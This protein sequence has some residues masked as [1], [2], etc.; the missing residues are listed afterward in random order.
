MIAKGDIL[1]I[2]VAVSIKLWIDDLAESSHWQTY[3]P[4]V[5]IIPLKNS[6]RKCEDVLKLSK[7]SSR[8]LPVQKE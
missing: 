2:N 3:V 6:L 8:Y 7:I 1:L 5:P 4:D